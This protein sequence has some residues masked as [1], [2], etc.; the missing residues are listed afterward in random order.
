MFKGKKLLVL[1]GAFQHCKVVE[2]AKEM[3]VKVYVAD[4]LAVEDSPA[5]RIA[6]VS[7]LI[8]IKDVDG[9]VEYCKQEKIDG[10]LAVCLDVC[11]R[12]YQAVC[13]KLN[14]PCFGTKE[15][16]H[17]LTDKNAFK[18]CCIKH[19]VD[20]IPQYTEKELSDGT[21]EYP[22]LIKP[23]DSRGSR[24]STICYNIKEVEDAITIAKSE[25]SDGSILIE[26]Y[27]G[28][29]NDFSVTYSVINGQVYLTRVGDR[30]LGK[31]EDRMERV[32]MMAM[33]P[34]K[35]AKMYAEKVSPRVEN[36]LKAIGIYNAPAFMQG[37][38][39]GDTVRFYDPGLRYPG[40]EYERMYEKV[41]GV[42]CVKHLVE[43]ALTGAVSKDVCFPKDGYLQKGKYS[44]CLFISLKPGKISNVLGLEEVKKHPSVVSLFTRYKVG[45]IIGATYNVNQ[46]YCE[47]DLLCKDIHELCSV[48]DWIYDTLMILDE[49]GNNMVFSKINTSSL[50]EE[51]Q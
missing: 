18:E 44:P 40:A 49:D 25:S 47:I 23:A 32:S 12:P 33:A 20:V 27:M 21:V 36:M 19:G 35:F 5:K 31:I 3:G 17:I 2:A 4:Y 15:Q 22:I 1:G 39:D 50:L 34:S 42:N 10:V 13:E 38:V 14:L 46:R 9:I 7:L 24:G 30:M 28:N 45:D 41:Y 43:F 37:F 26:K 48:I 11:Q 6:D 16:F 51:Y 8:D 29:K